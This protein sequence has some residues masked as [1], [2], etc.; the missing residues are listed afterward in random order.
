MMT[1]LLGSLLALVLSLGM[2]S[3]WAADMLLGSGD[4]LKITVFGSPDLTLE[5]RV[6]DSGSINY[7]LIGEVKV[8]GVSASAAEREIADRLSKGKFV[9]NPQ[10]NILVTVPQSQL[11]SVLGQVLKPGRYP[12]DG[13]HTVADMLALAGGVT[14][15]G[16]DSVTVVHNADGQITRQVIDM[17][18]LT[19]DGEN[20]PVQLPDVSS[21]DVVYVE[22]APRFYIYGEV[23]HPGMFRL[24]RGTTVLQALSVGGGLTLRGT[25]RGMLIKRRDASGV[26]KD[27][28][29]SKEDLLQP[30]DVVYVKES[31]F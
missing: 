22:R 23:Q 27:L 26:L 21:N 18:T 15:D 9:R 1:R 24:E 31:W 10:V 5:T 16:G 13:R 12:L 25:E 2:G 8:G 30:D 14:A 6:S 7:P 11:V 19:H 3:A 17:Y 4:V 28:K 20:G 29:T